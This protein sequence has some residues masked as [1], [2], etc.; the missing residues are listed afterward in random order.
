MI[1][2]WMTSILLMLALTL[3]L[4]RLC[5]G[6]TLADRILAA[7]L[8]GT[9]CVVLVALLSYL[10]MDETYLDI[11]LAYGLLNFIT[12]VALL[13]HLKGRGTGKGEPHG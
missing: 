12:T 7:N 6:P 8:F 1:V 5:A 11:A 9:L 13:R 4:V 2:L 10:L 3:T